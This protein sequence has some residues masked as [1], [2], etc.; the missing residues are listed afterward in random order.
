MAAFYLKINSSFYRI[1]RL[2]FNA[3][4]NQ[5]REGEIQTRQVLLS[6]TFYR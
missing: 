1:I 5:I 6:Y 4:S 3:E 2:Q